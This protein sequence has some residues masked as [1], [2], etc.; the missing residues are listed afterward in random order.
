MTQAS[1]RIDHKECPV[2]I[3]GSGAG[4]GTLANELA[5]M[6]IDVVV[7]EAGARFDLDSFLAD[8][9]AGP[10]SAW[11]TFN[12]RD[13]RIMTGSASVVADYAAL[14]TYVLKAVGGTTVHWAAQAYRFRE[15][16]W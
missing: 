2:V 12:W 13:R 11:E 5:Q 10:D 7:I 16:E 8:E 6:G 4:G 1:V 15:H 3:I 14:P 9:S